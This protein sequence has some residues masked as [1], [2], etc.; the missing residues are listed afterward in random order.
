[1]PASLV[2]RHGTV[3]DG[4]GG[5]ARQA[6]VVIDGDRIVGVGVVGELDAPELDATGHVV[7]P[8][9]INVLSHAWGS[10]QVDSTGGSDLLQGVTTEVFGESLS[11]GP[12]DSRL[13]ESMRGWG[14][15][16]ANY[17]LEF[18]RLSEGLAFLEKSGIAPNIA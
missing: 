4:T 11:L 9:F 18:D 7:A 15:F 10:L 5:A 12:S 14:E 6:D 3:V 2:I 17:R 1:M 16:G 13:A 8:G